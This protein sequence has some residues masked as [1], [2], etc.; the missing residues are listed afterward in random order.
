[1]T[2]TTGDLLPTE[3]P[4]MADQIACVRRE[5]AMR[6]NVYPKWVESGRLKAV[7]AQREQDRMQA[8]HDSLERLA[9][10]DAARAEYEQTAEPVREFVL[11]YVL[12]HS[13]HVMM[14]QK[15]ADMPSGAGLNGIGGR[16]DAGETPLAAMEREWSEE[17][18][19]HVPGGLDAFRPVGKFGGRGFRVHVFAAGPMDAWPEKIESPAIAPEAGIILCSLHAMLRRSATAHY[20]VVMPTEMPLC[21][22]VPT[23]LAMAFL[24]RATPTGSEPSLLVRT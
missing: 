9:I 4:S 3:P 12:T 24:E 13:G 7:E 14:I 21:P 10:I 6:R 17:T 15:T 19:R 18:G 22:W 11:G 2:E 5:I 1:M 20:G 16:I 8:V 23:T